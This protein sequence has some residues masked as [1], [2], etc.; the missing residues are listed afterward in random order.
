MI[1]ESFAIIVGLIGQFRSEK[2]GQAQLEYN[3]FMKWL[4]KAQHTE[5]KGV[6]ESNSNATIYIKELL[7][8]DH[9]TF[10]IKLD[11]IDAAITA[12][13]STI[14]GFGA[15][16][17]AVNPDSILSDQSINI[18][19]QFQE[20]GATRVLELKMMG[21]AQYMFIEKSGGLEITDPRFVED[22]LQTLLEYG[23]LRH[24]YN[25]KGENIY[26][27]TRAASRLVSD[28]NS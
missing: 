18:L 20:S 3:D 24:D 8:Q 23:L 7:E 17:K 4:A 22:D 21:G 6:L 9:E 28:K 2:G 1:A 5:I 26:I 14:D 12:F 10:K 13:A 11:K 27:F 16:A 15:L 19:E 25:K